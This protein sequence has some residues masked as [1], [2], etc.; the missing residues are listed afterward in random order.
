MPIPAFT[1]KGVLPPF[2][3]DA[4]FIDNSSPYPVTTLDLCSRF[5]L[6]PK[7]QEI[8]RGFLKFRG[9]LNDLLVVDGFQWVDGR[10]VEDDG[11]R[12]DSPDCIQVVTFCKDSPR[13]DDPAYAELAAPLHAEF[14]EIR[15][16]FLVDPLYVSLN[17][18]VEDIINNTRFFGATLS[19]QRETGLWKGMLQIPLSTPKDDAKAIEYLNTLDSTEA[20]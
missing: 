9:L 5:A 11:D 13:L 7:R 16:R 18:P 19:H 4:A 6:T 2:D 1:N 10:F 12:S 14:P 3:G 8:L 15:R 17:W 20:P